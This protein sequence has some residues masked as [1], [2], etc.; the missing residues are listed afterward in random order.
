MNKPRESRGYF[1]PST[2]L[3]FSPGDLP[4][5]ATTKSLR[6]GGETRLVGETGEEGVAIYNLPSTVDPLPLRWRLAEVYLNFPLHV[7]KRPCHNDGGV[8]RRNTF[9]LPTIVGGYNFPL[10]R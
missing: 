10:H 3:P 4:D 1:F 6:A 8:P 5:F 2:C 7:I 9:R